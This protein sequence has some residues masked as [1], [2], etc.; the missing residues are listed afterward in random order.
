MKI[1]RIGPGD[2]ALGD[3]TCYVVYEERRDTANFAI[4]YLLRTLAL[5]FVIGVER[6]VFESCLSQQHPF[7]LPVAYIVPYYLTRSTEYVYFSRFLFLQFSRNRIFMRSVFY[8]IAFFPSISSHQDPTATLTV[9]TRAPPWMVRQTCEKPRKAS[10][11]GPSQCSGVVRAGQH[12]F[13]KANFYVF[14]FQDTRA[15][16]RLLFFFFFNQKAAIYEEQGGFDWS[17]YSKESID[18]LDSGGGGKGKPVLYG[19][20]V[21]GERRAILC[22]FKPWNSLLPH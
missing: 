11:R 14:G 18:R 13:P 17:N 19:L 8:L 7:R 5:F 16:Q 3:I 1:P 9:T 12:R 20:S 10:S 21:E 22:A 15:L 6:K 4:K 2:L